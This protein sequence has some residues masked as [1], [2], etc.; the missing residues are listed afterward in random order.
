MWEH[1][2]PD[3]QVRCDMGWDRDITQE[4]GL[5]GWAGWQWVPTHMHT[6]IHHG[7]SAGRSASSQL[8]DPSVGHPP[9]PAIE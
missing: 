1:P 5:Q 8:V 4:D 9:M 7:T 6:Y 3:A 2:R